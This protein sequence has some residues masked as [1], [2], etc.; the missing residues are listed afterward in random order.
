VSRH[1]ARTDPLP[2]SEKRSTAFAPR[3]GPVIPARRWSGRFAWPG[4][5]R[6]LVY[7]QLLSFRHAQRTH[8]ACGAMRRYTTAPALGRTLP[9]MRCSRPLK[10]R[11]VKAR[12]VCPLLASSSL[13]TLT[14]SRLLPCR[15]R[16]QR[17]G[18]RQSSAALPCPCPIPKRQRTGA[19]QKADA[20]VQPPAAIS[21]INRWAQRWRALGPERQHPHSGPSAA[22]SALDCGSP[23][24]LCPGRVPKA[25][26]QVQLPAAT[27]GINR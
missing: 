24:P 5:L 19:V 4:R 6:R 20:P 15:I 27:S 13:L 14:F 26:A 1:V 23:L 25:D 12:K 10:A 22:R 8:A 7:A 18:V 16:A 3:P 11:K 9:R 2:G 21:G 17:L